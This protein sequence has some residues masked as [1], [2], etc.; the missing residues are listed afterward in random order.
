[1]KCSILKGDTVSNK[2]NCT[3][4]FKYTILEH[5]TNILVYSAICIFAFL[6]HTVNTESTSQPNK[7][8]RY[9][10]RTFF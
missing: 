7:I 1:M 9:A 3:G 5:G 10:L 4:K 2:V 8:Y 6:N